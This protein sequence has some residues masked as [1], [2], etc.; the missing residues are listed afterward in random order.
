MAT[1]EV[2]NTTIT[3]VSISELEG[4]IKNLND[5]IKSLK[6][7]NSEEHKKILQ[8]LELI[9]KWLTLAKSQGSWKSKTCKYANN[10]VCGAW[11]ISDPTRIGIPEDAIYIAPD[12]SRRV[13]VSKYYELC[14]TCPLYEVKRI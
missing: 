5:N 11:N 1:E 2:L 14:I 4:E 10:G 7:E 9:E 13:I 8:K 6:E 3:L 12:G